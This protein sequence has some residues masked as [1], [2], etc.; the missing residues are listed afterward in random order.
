MPQISLDEEKSRDWFWYAV[1]ETGNIARF[2]TGSFRSLPASVRSDQQRAE[3]LIHYFDSL[4]EIGG[5]TV[6]REFETSDIVKAD[7]GIFANP[8][9]RELYLLP[10]AGVGARGLFSYD[11]ALNP[12]SGYEG[13]TA[14]TVPISI[15]ALPDEIQAKLA[16]IRAPFRFSATPRIAE[17]DTLEW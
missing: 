9:K 16:G 5:C 3:D 17:A 1:D 15:S 6:R 14:P 7:P 11:T 2:A 10:S 13:V 12:F 4:K 8:A